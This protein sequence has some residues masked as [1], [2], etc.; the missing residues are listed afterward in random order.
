MG[1]RL[2]NGFLDVRLR[3]HRDANPQR[4]IVADPNMGLLSLSPNVLTDL[5]DFL[6]GV[7][8]DLSEGYLVVAANR[9]LRQRVEDGPVS[10]PCP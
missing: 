8:G 6:I 2:R 5:G 3:W 10:R 7:V 9:E 1:R 4:E